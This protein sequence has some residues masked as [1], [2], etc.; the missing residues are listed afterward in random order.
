M[1]KRKKRLSNLVLVLKQDIKNTF[2]P[3]FQMI[4][5]WNIRGEKI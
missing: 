2:E 4:T 5:T 1:R 3:K